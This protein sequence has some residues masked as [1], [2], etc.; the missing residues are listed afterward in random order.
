MLYKGNEGKVLA[1]MGDVLD[2]RGDV[3]VGDQVQD[4]EDHGSSRKVERDEGLM[5]YSAAAVAIKDRKRMGD[6]C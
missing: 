2:E 4:V 3:G 6:V 5:Y 1:L